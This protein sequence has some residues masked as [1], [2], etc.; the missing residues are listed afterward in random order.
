[1]HSRGG[2]VA[3]PVGKQEAPAE[4]KPPRGR[5]GETYT[6]GAAQGAEA[7]QGT[8]ST[9]QVTHASADAYVRQLRSRLPV[10]IVDTSAGVTDGAKTLKV[11]KLRDFDEVGAAEHDLLAMT[12]ALCILQFIDI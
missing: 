4:A 8:D 3:Q 2:R 5:E 1:M 6:P 9:S 10:L 7:A 12:G 11:R